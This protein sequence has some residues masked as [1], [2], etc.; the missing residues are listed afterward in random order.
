MSTGPKVVHYRCLP[1]KIPV[2]S[3]ITLWL[4]LDRLQVPA[5]VWG[6]VGAAY[7]ILFLLCVGAVVRQQD[8]DIFK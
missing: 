6:A 7:A 1:A 5:W 8:T 4:L 2:M 3:G